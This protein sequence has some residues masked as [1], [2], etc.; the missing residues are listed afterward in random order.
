MLTTRSGKPMPATLDIFE[1]ADIWHEFVQARPSYRYRPGRA[2]DLHGNPIAPEDNGQLQ[3]HKAPH[4]IRSCAPGNGWGKTAV[5][6][7]EV[8]WWGHGDHPWPH[9]IPTDRPRQMVWI[10]QT[11][12]QWELLRPRVEVWWPAAVRESWRGQPFFSYTWPDGSTLS[13]ITA[14][15]AWATVQGIQPDLVAGDEEIPKA[16]ASE[17][18]MRRRGSTKTRYVFNG[19]A[20]QGMTWM[21]HDIYAKWRKFHERLGITSETEM[22]RRQLHDFGDVVPELRGVPGIWCWP[23]GSHAENP[24]A[25][26]ATWAQQQAN[27]RIA[28]AN[29]AQ[30]EVRLHG[31]Y[32]D[33][34][35]QPV[36]DLDA[37]EA[38]RASV[39]P[40]KIGRFIK[41]V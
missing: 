21:Y 27:A 4:V 16:L 31:G 38:M 35:G 24:E 7:V 40:G 39:R 17:M 15:T 5:I 37:V 30:L 34:A 18:L 9:E 2:K 28:A 41:K 20:T 6:A 19:T 11:Y 32:R 29:A 10:A 1:A 33:F 26:T 25:T 14:E 8:D 23:R 3:F 13:V 22:M 12:K 36:F